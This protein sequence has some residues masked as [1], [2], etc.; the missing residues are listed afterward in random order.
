[1]A[2]GRLGGA[3][4]RCNAPFREKGRV[5]GPGRK[6]GGCTGEGGLRGKTY[7]GPSPGIQRAA[8]DII[9]PLL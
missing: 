4:R 5:P 8:C 1:M 2:E 7:T 3:G 9:Y 6:V